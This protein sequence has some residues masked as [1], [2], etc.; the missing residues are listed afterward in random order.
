[1]AESSRDTTQLIRLASMCEGRGGGEMEREVVQKKKM[2]FFP[3]ES[4]LLIEWV[5]EV[6]SKTRLEYE[7]YSLNGV[8]LNDGIHFLTRDN[9]GKLQPSLEP[10][11]LPTP[12]ITILESLKLKLFEVAHRANGLLVQ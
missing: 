2:A 10:D 7:A 4:L 11:I 6:P 8:P 9:W 5:L 12:Q 3:F 1:M